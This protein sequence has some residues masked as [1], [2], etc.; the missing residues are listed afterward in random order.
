MDLLSTLFDI[1]IGS[2][3]SYSSRLNDFEK[4]HSDSSNVDF[5]KLHRSMEA[6]ERLQGGIENMRNKLGK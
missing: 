4:A 5:E 2:V 1:L 6:S 3:S